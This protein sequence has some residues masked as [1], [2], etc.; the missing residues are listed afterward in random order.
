M[1]FLLTAGLLFL[2]LAYW[3]L[4]NKVKELEEKYE[5]EEK[6]APDDQAL[7][8]IPPRVASVGQIST[9]PFTPA[10]VRQNSI[11]SFRNLIRFLKSHSLFVIGGF[12]LA[13][14][15]LLLW[16]DL[17]QVSVG[18]SFNWSNL[19]TDY[20]SQ[21]WFALALLCSLTAYGLAKYNQDNVPISLFMLGALAAILLGMAHLFIGPALILAYCLAAFL[22]LIFVSHFGLPQSAFLVATALYL[23]PLTLV[24]KQG[25]FGDSWLPSLFYLSATLVVS[26][27]WLLHKRSIRIYPVTPM[28]VLSFG[29]IGFVGFYLTAYELTANLFRVD[30]ARVLTYV[31][32]AV[33]TLATVF[34]LLRKRAPV[35]IVAFVSATYLL[36]LYASSISLSSPQWLSG[37]NHIHGFGVLW[38]IVLMTLLIL[39]LTQ[40]YR[41]EAT[42]T[43]RH[44]I[45]LGLLFLLTYTGVAVAVINLG[46][47][48]DSILAE[49]ITYVAFIIVLYFLTSLLA[50]VRAPWYWIFVSGA[51]GIVPIAMSIPSF[52]LSFWKDGL[53]S[54]QLAGLLS[55][56]VY[57][58]LLAQSIK[59]RLLSSGVPGYEHLRFLVRGLFFVSTLYAF[60]IYWLVVQLL[61][62]FVLAQV[63]GILSFSVGSLVLWQ[64]YKWQNSK[65]SL[66]YC[67]FLVSFIVSRFFGSEWSD[68]PTS[69]KAMILVGV[70]ASCL[71]AAFAES[72]SKQ[73]LNW[74]PVLRFKSPLA[75]R[76][77]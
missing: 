2:A 18:T 72:F 22:G 1:E 48:G 12:T 11:S 70:G 37:V 44:A 54:P 16:W 52:G 8:M 30:D 25:L 6:V 50:I 10:V 59:Q 17:F 35:S 34:Y 64:M 63:I 20:Q 27:F 68:L 57:S 73:A 3:Q 19:L 39:L 28:V 41:R 61:L 40:A 74:G 29:L 14:G 9:P 5:S 66:F 45:G 76:D 23:L 21:L 71:V 55:V 65:A 33:Q 26:V 51:L 15:V 77:N 75:N 49:V 13:A 42:G 67:L 56:L 60:V 32:W 58:L 36:P 24:L 62:P 47:L 31:L 46:M 4:F 53:L 43:L 7:A 38:L 69:G